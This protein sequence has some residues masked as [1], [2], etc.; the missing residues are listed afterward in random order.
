MENFNP[1]DRHETELL[2]HVPPPDW[3]NPRASDRYNLVVIGAGPAGLV[4]AAG[5]AGLG[6]KVALIERHLMGGD[7][8]NVGC[9]PS[10]ALLRCAR[11][12]KEAREAARFG[13]RAAGVEV[14][15]ASVAERVRSLRAQLSH[16][17]SAS[18]F[19]S[20]GV[21]VFLGQGSFAGPDTISVGDQTLRFSKAV[22]ATGA[23]AVV[24]PI[25]GLKEV[26]CL[27]NETVFQL[28]D[29][30]K[31]LAIIGAGPIGC[32]M[33]QA[34][35]RLG[36]EVHL[37]EAESR[38]LPREDTDA[39]KLLESA[40]TQDG[41]TLYCGAKIEMVT[42]TTAGKRVRAISG[43]QSRDIVVDEILLGVG[44]A[45]NIEGLNLEAAA[46]AY[47]KTGVT[48]N[49]FLQTSNR[50]VYAAGDVCLPQ[51]FTHAADACARI[52]LQN[53]LFAGRRRV[54]SLV[55]PWCTYTDPEIAHVGAYESADVTTFRHDFSQVDRA[56]L[57]ADQGFVKV[58]VRPASDK[59]VGATI[60]GAH[61]GEMMGT[62]ALALSN[63]LGLNAIARTVFPYPTVSE[64]IKKAADAYSRTRLTPGIKRLFNWWLRRTR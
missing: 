17:D 1:V 7:C 55:I 58:H 34:F 25:P 44:R 52:V 5:A 51:K 10:K 24:L 15:F 49:D 45:P 9:V 43:G 11:A 39:A 16:H 31:R 42:R 8:L 12:A 3:Q 48:V 2:R 47:T 21:D 29:M 32:E 61:A 30:P 64:C 46:I 38:I 4:A 56:V 33:A 53:A 50:R 20:L 37:V 41:V 13:V 57:D 62:I 23:R 60:V 28:S 19:Q 54:S 26:G 59:I 22:I 35:A 27:T 14:D 18:R 63:E 6:A 40:L 36:A